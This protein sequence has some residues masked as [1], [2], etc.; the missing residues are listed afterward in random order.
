MIERI[1]KG[2]FASKAIADNDYSIEFEYND[3]FP[4]SA[5]PIPKRRFMPSK[6][7]RVKINKILQAIKLGRIDPKKYLDDSEEK[8]TPPEEQ[9]FDIWEGT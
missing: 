2:K 3:P 7:E 4:L 9:L 8:Q 6:H 1:R 5:A